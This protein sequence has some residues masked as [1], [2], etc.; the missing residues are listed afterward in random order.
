MT[1]ELAAEH[2][3]LHCKNKNT[4]YSNIFVKYIQPRLIKKMCLWQFI[5]KCDIAL[6]LACFMAV[7]K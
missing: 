4:M 5:C 6:L 7:S 3:A 1:G 2:S